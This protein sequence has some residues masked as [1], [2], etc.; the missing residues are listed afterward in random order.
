MSTD[1]SELY[2]T[3]K[4]ALET[5]PNLSDVYCE[6]FSDSSQI[7]TLILSRF[8]K[9]K[10]TVALTGDGGDE[11]FCG[12]NRYIFATNFGKNFIFSTFNKKINKKIIDEFYT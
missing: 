4:D 5:I 10:V 11:L 2:V 9:S 3:S 7:P 8:A 1:H 6:P 12:Y